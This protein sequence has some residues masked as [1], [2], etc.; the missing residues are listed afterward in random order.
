[1]DILEWLWS[2]TLEGQ[3]LVHWLQTKVKVKDGTVAVYELAVLLGLLSA[4]LVFLVFSTLS[5]PAL[6]VL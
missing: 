4:S 5:T 3:S 1:M 6:I 2:P